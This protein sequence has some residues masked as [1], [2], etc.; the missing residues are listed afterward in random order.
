[1]SSRRLTLTS[2][3]LPAV[4]PTTTR[5]PPSF[6]QRS[7][8][9]HAVAADGVDDEIGAAR[10]AHVVLPRSLG[11][12]HLVGAGPAR[13]RLLLVAGDDGERPRAQTLGDLQRRGA[14]AARRT[15]DEH[16]LRRLELPAHD[17][18]EVGGV[19]VEDQPRP[20]RDVERVMQ[21]EGE[22]GG[23]GD[24]LGEPAEQ[25][26]RGHPVTGPMGAAGRRAAHDARDLRARD[27]RQLGLELVLA[28]G[29]EQLRE[30]DPGGLHVDDDDGAVRC[31]RVARGGLGDVHEAEGAPARRARR[32]G[33]RAC[34]A[35]YGAGP[36]DQR[37]KSTTWLPSGM[38]ARNSPARTL[39]SIGVTWPPSSA[40]S[41]V[42]SPRPVNLE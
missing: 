11:A 8:S 31:E 27:E 13:D 6:R 12:E 9:S 30:R 15:V 1:M 19:V 38:R 21:A 36:L 26:H 22:E 33:P 16:G 35:P 5:R 3:M 40:A 37:P 2:G 39:S 7:E 25:A 23:R 28:T 17:Q 20:L 10:R 29:L 41:S 32:S 24:G 14:D 34:A 18:R 42:M 4:K